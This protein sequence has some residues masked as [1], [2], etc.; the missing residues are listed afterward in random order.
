MAAFAADESETIRKAQALLE[1]GDAAAASPLLE[2]AVARTPK[3]AELHYLL[4]RSYTLEAKQ[5]SNAVRLAYVGWNIG[6]ELQAALALDPSRNDARL[7]LIRYYEMTPRIVGGSPAKARLQA[8]ELAKHDA[9]LGA[10]AR[11]YLSYREKQYGPAR[12]SL[13]DA[14]KGARD[15]ATRI[16]ALTWLGWLSQETQ[17]YDEAF[18]AFDEILTLDP[19]HVSALY[20]IGRTALFSGRELDR[21]EEA[22]RKYLAATPK[23]DDPPHD[24]AQKCLNE[25]LKRKIARGTI[26]P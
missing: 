20:E 16:L 21:G 4:A 13:R 23:F 1:R 24:E 15:D 12:Q 25:L 19:K 8:A 18:R 17:Q 14:V 7:D 22:L 3:S 9:A 2:G 10:F 6:D 11:G 26:S 5:S